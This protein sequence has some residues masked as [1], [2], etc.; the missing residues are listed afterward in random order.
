MHIKK[1]IL[2]VAFLFALIAMP[3]FIQG[4]IGEFSGDN[5]RGVNPLQAIVANLAKQASKEQPQRDV[6]PLSDQQ[7]VASST[8]WAQ[9]SGSFDS[10]PALNQSQVSSPS[11]V[12]F[13]GKALIVGIVMYAGYR[14]SK[15][16]SVQSVFARLTGFLRKISPFEGLVPKAHP[17]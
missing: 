13:I 7:A 5:W 4:S 11:T 2:N 16:Q 6:E 8:A 10:Q 3:G 17:H 12:R 9:T 1:Q 14:L 15:A